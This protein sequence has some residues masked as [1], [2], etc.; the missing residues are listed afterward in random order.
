LG[1]PSAV[2]NLGP[3]PSIVSHGENGLVFEAANPALI[4][5][6]LKRA[7]QTPNLLERLSSGART[8]F[9]RLYTEDA[10]YTTMMAIY[11]KAKKQNE[12]R[13]IK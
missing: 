12:I 4:L 3:L 9:E 13:D 6:E 5:K 2:S 1:T 8:T 7:W 10:N 11:E